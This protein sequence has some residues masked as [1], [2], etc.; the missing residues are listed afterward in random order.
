MRQAL[1][2]LC[3]GLLAVVAYIV[4]PGAAFAAP[5]SQ[6]AQVGHTVN[7]SHFLH[8]TQGYYGDRRYYRDDENED[9]D[10][11]DENENAEDNVD[12]NADD[13]VDES[14]DDHVDDNDD[15]TNDNREEYASPPPPPP[16]APPPY[17]PYRHKPHYKKWGPS[18]TSDGKP[19]WRS[20]RFTPE[21]CYMCLGTCGEGGSC[22]PRC[23]GWRNYCKKHDF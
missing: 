6:A 3:A 5:M 21:F 22:A 11:I 15:D 17:R 1:H 9:R 12:E 20:D 4:A 7:D 16:P 13:R 19:V 10:T 2:M 14:A 8:Y 23:W 18:W